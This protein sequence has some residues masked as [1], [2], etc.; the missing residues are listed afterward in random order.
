MLTD[1]QRESVQ[2]AAEWLGRSDDIG[3]QK[4]AERLRALLATQAAEPKGLTEEQRNALMR[5]YFETIVKY[6]EADLPGL[7]LNTAEKARALLAN[8]E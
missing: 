2:Y 7:A 3:N 4:H 5:S 6:L 1:E 8:G